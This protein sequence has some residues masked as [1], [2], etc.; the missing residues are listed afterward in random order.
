MLSDRTPGALSIENYTP[1]VSRFRSLF[2]VFLDKGGRGGGKGLDL[3]SPGFHSTASERT[4]E[5]QG[6]EGGTD[7]LP[8]GEQ[9]GDGEK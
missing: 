8:A 3:L 5:C 1:E 6:T 9:E 2:H 7:G 4:R